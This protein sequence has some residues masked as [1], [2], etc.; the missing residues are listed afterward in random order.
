MKY[1]I[2][3]EIETEGNP[4][5]WDWSA[6]FDDGGGDTLLSVE[7]KPVDDDEEEQA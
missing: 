4:R 7:S 5:K 2:T 3:L 1:R 6:V